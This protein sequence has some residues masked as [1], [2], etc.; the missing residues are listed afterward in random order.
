[1]MEMFWLLDIHKN[2]PDTGT[3]IVDV[4]GQTTQNPFYPLSQRQKQ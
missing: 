1:M 4:M 3:W 2:I